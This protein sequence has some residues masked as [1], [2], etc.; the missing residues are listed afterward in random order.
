M[1]KV[2]KNTQ[3]VNITYPFDPELA[4]MEV[5]CFERSMKI[6]LKRCNDP[7]T[8]REIADVLDGLVKGFIAKGDKKMLEVA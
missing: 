3:A 5:R 8:A 4:R 6:H 1:F 7:E 2:I